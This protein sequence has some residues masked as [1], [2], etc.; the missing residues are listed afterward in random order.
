MNDEIKIRK[1]VAN[2]KLVELRLITKLA[3]STTGAQ[4]HL[5]LMTSCRSDRAALEELLPSEN[6]PEKRAY[7]KSKT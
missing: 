4:A 3:S 5:G 6:V 2:L 1:A 7:N